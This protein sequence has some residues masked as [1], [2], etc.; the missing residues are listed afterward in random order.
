MDREEFLATILLMGFVHQ[1]SGIGNEYVRGEQMVKVYG[2]GAG[3]SSRS[4]TEVPFFDTFPMILK[5]LR[6]SYEIHE[7]NSSSTL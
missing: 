3:K 4:K 1:D 6:R 2:R 5:Q 7:N